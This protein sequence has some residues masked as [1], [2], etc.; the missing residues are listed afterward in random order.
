M[1]RISAA[2]ADI[3]RTGNSP[4]LPPARSGRAKLQVQKD[5]GPSSGS[6][7]T[8]A[9]IGSKQQL[10]PLRLRELQRMAD[11]PLYIFVR[12]LTGGRIEPRLPAL[13]H[14]CCTLCPGLVCSLVDCNSTPLPTPAPRETG[15]PSQTSQVSFPGAYMYNK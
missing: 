12:R 5:G 14:M 10:D 1:A 13:S 8:R 7:F 2:A 11:W 9:L 15:R 3:T 6:P 4:S